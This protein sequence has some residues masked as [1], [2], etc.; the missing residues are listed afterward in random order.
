MA[1]GSLAPETPSDQ[2]CEHCRRYFASQGIDNHEENCPL[3]GVD[4]EEYAAHVT[5]SGAPGPDPHEG[6]VASDAGTD[7][8][9]EIAT[10]GG[11]GLGLEGKP[12]TSPSDANDADEDDEELA[13]TDCEEPLGVTADDLAAD[14]D[15]EP[16]D[17]LF[18]SCGHEMEYAP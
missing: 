11:S 8:S 5:E 12:D 9:A 7:E 1:S 2:S 13:C 3:Q 4:L 18:C 6:T 15:L 14:E 16:G 17:R 10:D